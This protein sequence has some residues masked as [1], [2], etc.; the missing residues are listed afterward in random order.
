L[1]PCKPEYGDTSKRAFDY[2]ENW[3]KKPGRL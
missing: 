3:L 1:Q 2:L